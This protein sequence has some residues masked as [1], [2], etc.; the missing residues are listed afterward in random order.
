V[1][2]PTTRR[3]PARD[4]LVRAAS[5]LF[6][7]DGINTVGVDRVVGEA[8]VAK[9]SLYATFGSKEELVRAYLA[10]QARRWHELISTEI[11]LRFDTPRDQ[12]VG[13]FDVLDD[14]FTNGFGG[15]PFIKACGEAQPSPAVASETKMHRAWVH[16]LFEHLAAEADAKNPVELASHLTLLYHGALV[17]AHLDDATPVPASFARTAARAL[18]EQ[19]CGA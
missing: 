12:L 4:R 3:Q 1:A 18:V 8:G 14:V 11:E 17:S 7:A 13:V 2:V 16:A 6:Y 9:A 19:A 15:C 10:D 5:K